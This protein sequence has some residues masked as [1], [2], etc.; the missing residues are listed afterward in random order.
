MSRRSPVLLALLALVVAWSV[1]AC[2]SST[3]TPSLT[4][5][6][7]I[8]TKSIQTLKEIKT[9]HLQMDVSGQVK[10]DPSM[11]GLGGSSTPSG[12]T[13][14]FDLKGTTAQG[15]I[16][17]PNGKAH[18]S[19]SVPALLGLTADLIVI[20]DTT[21]LKASLLGTKYQK[22]TGA[23]ALP[24]PLPSGSPNEQAAI[25]Q[26]NQA[27]AK[28]STPPKLIGVEQIAGKP[29]YH[30]ELTVSQQDLGTA[31]PSALTTVSGVTLDVWS[32]VDSL[33]PARLELTG[34]DASTG[35]LDVVLTFTNYD[36]SVTIQAPPADQV[37]SSPATG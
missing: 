36:Q 25:D 15:D 37:E 13:S 8:L 21:Y 29:A 7:E 31:L 20:G 17:I 14:S 27:L 5:P 24:V 16:D 34:G 3:P 9:V 2:G 1:G 22:S 11:L 10:F 28:L 6:K 4:D 12:A 32:Y 18:F 35:T 33:R 26:L 23:S 30:V 19:A